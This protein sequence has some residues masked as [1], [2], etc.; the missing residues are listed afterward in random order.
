MP[1]P[2]DHAPARAAAVRR[3]L[4]RLTIARK[5][6]LAVVAAALLSAAAVG[7]ASYREAASTIREEVE[8][9]LATLMDLRRSA[10]EDYLG[11]IRQDLRILSTSETAQQAVRDFTDAWHQLGG[12]AGATLQRHYITVNPHPTGKKEE[13]DAAED[14]S[15]YSVYHGR[16]HPWFRSFLR[17]RGY[18]DIFLFDPEGNLVYTVF[19]ELDFATNLM[20][21]QWKESD[22]GNVFRAALAEP[23]AGH[24][25][26]FDFAPYAP[27]HDVPAGFVSTPIIGQDGALLGVLAFQMPIDNMN[28]VMQNTAGL[29]ETGQTVLVGA[30][31][32]LR[33]DSRFSN[34]S[35]ILKERVDNDATARA[36]SGQTGVI[37]VEREGRPTLT[38][39]GSLD[40]LGTRWALLAEIASEE[41]FA[42]I[43]ASRNKQIVLTLGILA[44]LSVLGYLVSLTIVRPLQAMTAAMRALAGGDKTIAVPGR[45]RNDEL[46]EMAA[47]VQV[48]KET[49]VEAERLAAEQAARDARAEA[50]KRQ[51]TLKLAEDLEGSIKTA[52]DAVSAAVDDM[53]GAAER[54]TR[55]ATRT[56]E[57][58]AEVAAAA[59]QASANVQTVA[60]ASEELSG[61]IQEISRQ[62]AQ[63]TV[64]AGDAVAQ[65]KQAGVTVEGLSAGARKIGD[66]VALIND[67]A[68][69]T[70][71][72]ALNA[73]IEAAR[74]GEAG[75]G[76]A[77]VA[78][79]VKAL[80]T[81]TARATGEIGQ[82][83]A[84]MQSAT[85]ETVKAIEDVRDAIDRISE[86]CAG[87]ASAVKQQNA[88]TLEISRNVQEAATG[89][90]SVSGNIQGVTEA[91]AETGQ[92]AGQV[93]ETTRQL[94]AEADRLRRSVAEI[95][96]SMRAA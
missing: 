82:Q 5:L 90:Q 66:V 4:G 49:A 46:G 95:L 76:F 7:I 77:V 27:S 23:T 96:D 3:G 9:K 86:V 79:E 92:A 69:Q 52:V 35:T 53:Q 11:S 67:I 80:A 56:D 65:V 47:T 64:I 48:F 37:E 57:Q 14:G 25:A 44:V 71:L 62:V 33:S 8:V 88:A 91:S 74:A 29:G 22:L 73:T 16:Y 60:T 43:V 19:K 24:Q 54:M 51:A 39:Y 18:Y 41:A 70:N 94:A 38:A 81:Q 10:L 75:K 61:S 17:E 72:L 28:R 30:D 78:S 58:A 26:F 84:G 12:E 34:E 89:T 42:D 68:E 21:G 93:S 13:L 87:I 63:S 85:A 40:F 36:L 6:P 83:I 1:S 20:T 2:K 15:L 32:L 50:E 59:E 31:L 55:S 45:D